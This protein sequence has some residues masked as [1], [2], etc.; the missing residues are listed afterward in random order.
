M[1]DQLPPPPPPPPTQA[2]VSEVLSDAEAEVCE[3]R[4]WL[5]VK[6]VPMVRV[7]H[8][9]NTQTPLWASKINGAPYIPKAAGTHPRA[10]RL[11]VQINFADL[12]R[13]TESWPGVPGLPD[14]GLLQIWWYAHSY[15]LCETGVVF[16]E[17]VTH[18]LTQ[19]HTTFPCT[20]LD[21]PVEGDTAEQ[22]TAEG[23]VATKNSDPNR[24]VDKKTNTDGV[25]DKDTDGGVHDEANADAVVGHVEDPETGL[26][27]GG[28]EELGSSLP[29]HVRSSMFSPH[30]YIDK[31]RL[32]ETL[33][34][35]DV[36]W[37]PVASCETSLPYELKFD[38]D[39]DIPNFTCRDVWSCDEELINHLSDHV[40]RVER[41]TH[42]AHEPFGHRLS[43]SQCKIGGYPY[44]TQCDS[45]ERPG[46][47]L[48]QIGS[49]G[50]VTFG[51]S[52]LAHWFIDEQDLV[53]KKFENLYFMWDCC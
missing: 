31:G 26:V 39:F 32:D 53:K 37:F 15:D 3:Y 49:F 40:E 27:K 18:D 13:P 19:L 43:S 36:D 2:S 50:D 44:F 38:R 22:G 29:I 46:V 16:Y 6:R 35:P 4:S 34:K 5:S 8:I 42:G 20:Y 41:G 24:T 47:H 14:K 10:W 45:E 7:E 23:D 17:D 33:C 30:G 48:L 21:A 12:P 11:L 51:D 1:M 28:A 9:R 52:G 25:V